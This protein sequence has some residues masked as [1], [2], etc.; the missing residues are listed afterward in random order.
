LGDK[1]HG[2]GEGQETAYRQRYLDMIF[3]RETLERMKLRSKFLQVIRQFY[4]EKDFIEIETPIL[5]NSASGAAARPFSSHHNDFDLDMYLRIS[6]ETNLK[7]ATVGMVEKIFEIGKQFRN[8]GSDPSHH[9]EFTSI[10]HY[11]AYWNHE[12]NMVFT[13]AMFDYIFAHIPA[14]KK[15][16]SVTDKDGVSKEVNFQT[17]WPRIDYIAQIKKDSG[18]DVSAYTDG[19]DDRLRGDI[20]AT[21]HQRDN[22]QN[23]GLATMIDY[24]YKKVSRPKIV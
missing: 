9:Q 14:L 5:G 12:D 23:Q 19:D 6:P 24:L 15:T 8:E 2:I 16:L 20:I 3:N 17:P 18:I 11:A 10:E 21:G 4:R 7:K 22:I 13:E 1:F